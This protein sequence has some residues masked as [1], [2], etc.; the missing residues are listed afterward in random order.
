MCE[1][2]LDLFR[3]VLREPGLKRVAHL[4][5]GAATCAYEVPKE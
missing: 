2:E 5:D 3:K 4:R 1:N